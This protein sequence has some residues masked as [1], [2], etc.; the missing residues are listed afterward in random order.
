MHKTF[1]KKYDAYV[2]DKEANDV[3]SVT[4]YYKA[5]LRRELGIKI[6]ETLP[7]P[8]PAAGPEA[9]DV[10]MIEDDTEIGSNECEESGLTVDACPDSGL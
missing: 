9:D 5:F 10:L 2:L 6:S 1:F 7:A 4:A 8:P 3:P